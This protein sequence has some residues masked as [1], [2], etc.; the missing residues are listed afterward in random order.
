MAW[1]P[2]TNAAALSCPYPGLRPFRADEAVVFFGR[3]EQID[4]LLD[5][6]GRQRFLAVV[7]TSGCGKSSLI[8]AGLIPALRTGL[9]GCAGARWAVATMRPGDRPLW[10]LAEALL[11]K[12]VLGPAW[13][14]LD[15]PT[16]QVHACL[17]RGPLGLAE[18]LD[19]TPLSGGRKLLLVVDQF[20]EL[21]RY[22]REG[23]GQRDEAN[24]FV[25]LLLATVR[26]TDRPVYIVLT[27]RSDYLGDCA[28][29]D[30]LPE[31]LNDSQF[32][33]PKLTR[34]QR[35]QAIEGPARVF[36][37]QVEPALVNRLL[38][39]MGS[40]TDQL[41]L[42]QHALMRLWKGSDEASSLNLAGYEMLGGL[43]S[44]LSDQADDAYNSLDSEQKRI[45]EVLF[46][47]LSE[48]TT[49]GREIRR[50]TRLEEVAQ[51]AGVTPEEVLAVVDVFRD[52]DRSYLSPPWPQEIR[53]D[54][55]L[56][57]SHESLIRHW[58]RLR[59]WVDDEAA[60]AETYR[61]LDQTARLWSKG[62]AD[63][64]GSTDIDQTVR[65]KDK[66]RPNKAW[67]DR[68]GGDFDQAIWFL[69][70]SVAKREWEEREELQR[71]DEEL[72]RN[73]QLAE[74]QRQRAEEAEARKREAEAAARRQKRLSRRFLSA[75]LA[76]GVFAV[77]SLGLALWAN[78]ERGQSRQSETKA[79]EASN[80]AKAEAKRA[81]EATQLAETNEERAKA[82]AR[83]A[84]SRQ[85]AAV[86][87]T[88]RSKHLDRSLLL[89][90]E[91]LRIENTFE[92][93]ESLFK[94]LQEWPR[95]KTFLHIKEG[96]VTC[97]AFS[98][99]G[100]TIAAG[101]GGGGGD[102]GVMLW[103]VAGRKRLS[104]DPL[105][106]R[107]GQVECVAF[108]P[109]GKAVAV[110]YNGGTGT[111]AGGVALWDVA[112][113]KRLSDDPLPVKEGPISGVAF[114]PDGKTFAA[115]YGRGSGPNG[116]GVVLWDVAG[117]K[118]L[119]EGPLPLKEGSVKGLAFSPDGKTIAVGYDDGSGDQ[120]V[121]LWDVAGRKR[122]PEGPLPLK[123]GS[124]KGLAFSPD[125]KTI[126][127]GYD[128]SFVRVGGVVLLDVATRKRLAGGPLHVKEGYVE[129]VAF[130]SDGKTIAA[131]YHAVGFKG[132]GVMLW[133][134][135]G[136]KRLSDN[137][138]PVKEGYVSGLAFSPDGTL[139]ASF[140]VGFSGGAVVLWDVAG[141]GHLSDDR[142]AV[143]EGGVDGV[144]F[145]PDGKSIAAGFLGEVAF[146]PDGKTIPAGF[147]P[148]RAGVVLWDVAAR[149]RL[150]KDPLAVTEGLIIGVA[151]SP[152]GKTIA[153]AYQVG[154]FGRAGGVVL[155]DVAGSKRL[156]DN[157]L[158]V[159]EGSVSGVAFSPDGKTIAAAYYNTSSD[160]GGVVLWDL[161]ERKR[162]SDDPLPVKEGL[163][164]GVAF[165]PDGKF[166]AAGYGGS[167][168]GGVALWDAAG[169]K[170]LSDDPIPVKESS[171]CGVAFSPDGK[172]IAAPYGMVGSGG[173]VL[174][175]LAGRKRLTDDPFAVNEGG[176]TGV[177]FSPDGKT[178][179]AGY[180]GSDRGGV[181]LWDVAARKRLTDDPIPMKDKGHVGS[182]AFSPDCKTIAAGY[183]VE[184]GNGGVV[185]LDVDL[186][187]WRR[188]AG[189][190]ANRNFTR[191][192]WRLF[193]PDEAY[194]ATFPD[195]PVP[196]EVPSQR[197]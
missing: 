59:D 195:L 18:V 167:H 129:G 25:S 24:A 176:V 29:F 159:N 151:F 17:Q 69:E 89:A 123:E 96:W 77:I 133:D 174:L 116:G 85:L 162:L 117:R 134:V 105:T 57:I 175:D 79:T 51:V 87:A 137:P 127:A 55:T 56:D 26:E 138:L 16:A 94:T 156:S 141:R 128:D 150:V 158:P 168:R 54:D 144:A 64:W 170:R 62:E 106:V 67:A 191:N 58:G 20:E 169:R 187:S 21:F 143:E 148:S 179:A 1:K 147:R 93:R 120:G 9:L 78:I 33:T 182:V 82:Q 88:E 35:T 121:V 98:P 109:D 115:G 41:P 3:D 172:T 112:T 86:S 53:P 2:T 66:A 81:K 46:R 145:S 197:E 52:P 132:G 108:S 11:D 185:L 110:G 135:A 68:Y 183:G 100:K 111:S 124:M 40:G 84:N 101:Y 22:R 45:A 97:V 5:R 28:L 7:G 91:A 157:P 61:R 142:L 178:F 76:A 60:L 113:R 50:P 161:A 72:E 47:R 164:T 155:W 107:E 126:A 177:A 37:A 140:G 4:Q 136:R 42:L 153:A 146:T 6:L 119:P 19:E 181:V 90:V 15:H 180:R 131:A 65:W 27:M 193:F 160:R 122:L 75:A 188:I 95:V 80:T 139:A 118:R 23:E 92:A 125:G 114:S 166:I 173:V 83:I 10:R 49:A 73:R 192:E 104:G 71:R 36:D 13:S 12:E 154:G 44:A 32:L 184:D 163:A 189:Q 186:E 63:L 31:A 103:D 130:S 194:H 149:E 190:I 8:Y 34:T 196:P 48:R 165:S 38:N 39:D 74:A 102:Y 30:G 43:E 70:E 99:N 171:V 152:D 14:D